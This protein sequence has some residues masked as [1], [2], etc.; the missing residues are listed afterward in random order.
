M[1]ESQKLAAILAADVVGFTWMTG[2][3]EDRTLA[4]SSSAQRSDRSHHRRAQRTCVQAHRR[5]GAGRV[6]QRR[7]RGSMRHRSAKCYGRTQRGRRGRPSHRVPYRHSFRRR[8][9]G[10]RRGSYGR[11]RQ[12]RGAPGRRRQ[13]RRDL[14]L[15]QA[16][17]QV[18]ARLDISVSDLGRRSS[19]TSPSRSAPIRSRSGFPPKPGRPRGSCRR[20]RRGRR[21]SLP[22]QTNHR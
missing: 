4:R 8:R 7:R 11:G 13:A 9:R 17:W 21:S 14:P 15:R 5:W 6:S 2:A 1:A 16:Y 10:E 3:D 20:Q 19:R 22:C 12:H 18:K